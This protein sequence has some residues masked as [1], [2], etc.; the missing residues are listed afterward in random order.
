MTTPARAIVAAAP[1]DD[2]KPGSNWDLQ[3][4]NVPNELKDG[5]VLVEMV[6]SGICHTD[7][8]ITSFPESTPGF[9]FPRVAGHE[10]SGYV[11]KVGPK[12][13]KDLKEGDPVLLSFDYCRE[14]ESCKAGRLPYCATFSPLNLVGSEGVFK[15][16]DG[17][18]LAGKFFGHSSFASLSPVNE[19]CV[20]P[21]K[22]FVKS[23]EE[24]QLFAPL[25]CGIQTGAGAILNLTKPG[26]EDRVMILGL[27]GVGLSAVMVGI[28][29]TRSL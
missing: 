18:D 27:G 28:V 1:G 2:H 20:L 7:I 6:A 23:K 12:V 29:L 19:A 25:G 11:K 4:I 14:C 26:K 24:L 9:A 17:K 13:T 5:E 10:G 21:A 15:S 8:L 16:K 3:D 22:D